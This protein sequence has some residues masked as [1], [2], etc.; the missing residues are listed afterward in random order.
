MA[1]C[2]GAGAGPVIL[3]GDAADSHA[4]PGA[5][6]DLL[7]QLLANTTNGQTGILVLGADVESTAAQWILDVAAALPEPQALAF[8][9]DETILAISFSGYAALY[10]PSDNGTTPGGISAAETGYLAAR[11]ADVAGYLTAGGGLMA[12][13]QGSLPQPYGYMDAYGA[14]ESSSV[15][16][17]ECAPEQAFDN[18][19]A[20]PTGALLGVTDAELDG[21]CWRGVFESFPPA[22]V[23]LARANEPGCPAVDG[24]AVLL[25]GF[26]EIDFDEPAVFPAAG[27]ARTETLGDVDGDGDRDVIVTIPGPVPTLPG[28]VQVFLNQG[29]DELGDWQGLLPNPPVTVGLD[30]TAVTAALLNADAHVDLAVTNGGDD[31]VSILINDGSGSGTFLPASVVPV[32]DRPSAIVARD[33]NRDTFVDLAV[34]HELD[35]DFIIL[36]NDGD[37]NFGTP[38]V[39]QPPLG[40][41]VL[42]MSVG[43]F[44]NSKDPDLVGGGNSTAVAGG[45]AGGFV[46]VAL[47]NGNGT[48]AAPVLYPVGSDPRDVAVADADGDGLED[49]VS[50]NHGDGTVSLLKNAGGGGTFGAAIPIAVGAAPTSVDAAD[51][52]GDGDP[53]L[54]VVAVDAEAGPAVQVLVNTSGVASGPS[55][56]PPQAFTVDATPQWV[57]AGPL[58][59]DD[60][61]DVATSNADGGAG[62]VTVLINAPSPLEVPGAPAVALDVRPDACPNPLNPGSNGLLPVA[63]VGGAALDVTDVDLDTLLLT[64]A[65]GVG[66]PVQPVG[67]D[68]LPLPPFPSEDPLPHVVVLTTPNAGEPCACDTVGTDGITD[69]RLTFRTDKVATKLELMTLPHGT[70]VEVV[71]SGE[72]LDGSPFAVSDCIVVAPPKG[73]PGLLSVTSN[74]PGLFI[75]C[76]P[77]DAQLDEGGF[78]PFQR[79][80]ALPA[81]VTLSAPQVCM[82]RLFLG[83]KMGAPGTAVAAGSAGAA[84]AL[85]PGNVLTVPITGQQVAV[86]AVY[87]RLQAD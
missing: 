41:A 26:V 29:T 20:T 46:F 79:A 36:L 51:F 24:K 37:G 76:S 62:S 56:Q 77:A 71:L 74:V 38:V 34:A 33:F 61:P 78:A 47:G 42:S 43:D 15:P 22:L 7:Q 66:Q 12:L 14:V 70:V 85:I 60:L 48:F 55:F 73:P 17:G 84:P 6:A 52:D 9:N 25:G 83:W 44:D 49:I 86:H 63:L 80:F 65:D 21:C 18:V 16:G 57:V 30:P 39:A 4:P 82:G 19:S 13:T 58:D 81:T 59:G 87:L 67:L 50:A 68:G 2:C 3:S 8:V 1:L 27:A 35:E 72:R 5:Y 31:T 45:P 53:D 40:L 75:A 28:T 10:V 11:A 69:L 32:G 64:R 23:A 54:A